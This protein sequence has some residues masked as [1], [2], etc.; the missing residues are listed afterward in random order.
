MTYF[1]RCLSTQCLP[2]T[3]SHW[4]VIKQDQLIGVQQVIAQQSW[5]K[6]TIP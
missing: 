2:I 6:Y 4:S 3:H 1:G 5:N